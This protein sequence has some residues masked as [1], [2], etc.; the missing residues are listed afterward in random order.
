MDYFRKLDIFGQQISFEDNNSNK[1]KTWQGSILT[2]IIILTCSV[3]SFLFGQEVYQRQ[4][5]NTRYSKS[6]LN[7]SII[8]INE[9]PI[10]FTLID[11]YGR[12]VKNPQ[13]YVNIYND[14]FSFDEFLRPTMKKYSLIPCNST[15][16][17]TFN[18]LVKN[19]ICELSAGCMCVDPSSNMF[20]K[21]KFGNPNSQFN[22]IG[23]YPCDPAKQ[24]CASDADE[25]I[26]N[27]FVSALVVNSFINANNY[28][29]PV[30]RYLDNYA[31]QAST[32][33]YKRIFLSITNNT[34]ISDNGWL[35]D[36]F[37]QY[38]YS[39]VSSIKAEVSGYI[40][41]LTPIVAFT[42]DSP[43]ISDEITRSYM[44]VQD[45]L[46]KVGGII[47]ALYIIS[48]FVSYHYL[49]FLYIRNINEISN[50]IE[51]KQEK[52]TI[53]NRNNQD[54]INPIKLN[55][56][57]NNNKLEEEVNAERS[58]AKSAVNLNNSIVKK[59]EIKKIFTLNNSD[60][61]KSKVEIE[62]NYFDYITSMIC[63]TRYNRFI[64]GIIDDTKDKMSIITFVNLI[65]YS[66]KL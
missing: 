36:N 14:V 43:N 35:L 24:K 60:N 21:N 58:K 34:F 56:F 63:C 15:I 3:I 42:I 66:K 61:N 27:L 52:N 1:Y 53:I 44:K 54:S 33:F 22:H 12:M 23:F 17:P 46:A 41:G 30:V 5:S 32:A 37:V 55:N 31:Y 62:W 59:A 18:E 40:K 6:F 9:S 29:V 38:E 2:I 57:L 64:S 49:R 25:F 8:Y 39:Q 65:N 7:S 19:S 10:L 11:S 48:S 16:V 26:K 45:L 13:D 51:K 20:F 47:N 50:G 4:Q 28:S